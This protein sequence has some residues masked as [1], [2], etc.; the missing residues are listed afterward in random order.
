MARIAADL[1]DDLADGV[2]RWDAG[3]YHWTQY[4]S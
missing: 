4:G 2:V 1:L 3:I